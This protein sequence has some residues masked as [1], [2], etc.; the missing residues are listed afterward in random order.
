[1]KSWL[2]KHGFP[3]WVLTIP[4]IFHRLETQLSTPSNFTEIQVPNPIFFFKKKTILMLKSHSKP[5]FHRGQQTLQESNFFL[6]PRH[7]RPSRCSKDI[8]VLAEAPIQPLQQTNSFALD[9][10][11][12]GRPQVPWVQNRLPY[13]NGHQML[14]V[15]G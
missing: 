1:M 12:T 6:R 5:I 15:F 8:A 13:E 3:R 10:G 11:D 14:S 7:Q 9:A 4:I 2:V